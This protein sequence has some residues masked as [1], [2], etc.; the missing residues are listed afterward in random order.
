MSSSI[1]RINA[2][3][4]LGKVE[5]LLWWGA[6]WLNNKYRPTH[7]PNLLRDQFRPVLAHAD[8]E[9]D[10]RKHSPS[11]LMSNLFFQQ[12]DWGAVRSELGDIHVFDSGCGRGILAERINDLV[13]GYS[14]YDGIDLAEHP[15]WLG[16]KESG[17]PV[18]FHVGD[19]AQVRAF[20]PPEANLFVSQSSL[21]HFPNDLDFFR[22]ISEHVNATSNRVIQIHLFQSSAGLS[23]YRFHGLRQY[24]P[25]TVSKFANMFLNSNSYSVLYD[26]GGEQCNDLH[27]EFIS[28][29]IRSSGVDRRET[30]TDLYHDEMIRAINEDSNNPTGDP[31]WHALVIHS[32]FDQ[33]VF[34]PTNSI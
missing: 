25:R 4:G 32:N 26:F 20:I 29:P 16:L 19:V 11:R 30:E 10:Q 9:D 27:R 5:R 14:R 15:E 21:E 7:A 23:L 13:G 2:D 6:N 17:L 33:P 34:A 12:F 1:H 18:N 31:S 22:Q 24:T 3:T 8:L 28:K